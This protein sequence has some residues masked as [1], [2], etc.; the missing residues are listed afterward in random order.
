MKSIVQE[1][2]VQIARFRSQLSITN[3]AIRLVW[4]WAWLF[5]FRPSPRIA[6]GWRRFILRCFGAKIGRG[7]RI[8]NSA[9]IFYPPHLI[10][11]EN[12][13]VG[14][15]VDLYCVDKIYIQ[16]D[17]MVSQYSFICTASHDYRQ[18]HLPLI[19][20]P[21]TIESQAWV[22]A[23]VF[24]GPGVTIHTGAVVGA[25]STVTRNVEAWM[26]VAGNPAQ[27]VRPRVLGDNNETNP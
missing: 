2:K 15:D 13:V 8:Y 1:K 20:S 17:S 5:L 27:P 4:G 6:F 26:V 19:T 12:V 21:V 18:P 9:R 22:C 16:H 10:L 24:V 25:R 14:P 7:V 11:E 3:R 23:D